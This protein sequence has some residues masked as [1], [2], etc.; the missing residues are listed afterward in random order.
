[1]PFAIRIATV[2]STIVTFASVAS[3]NPSITTVGP[4][5]SGS[6]SVRAVSRPR[7]VMPLRSVRFS[8]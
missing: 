3:L 8:L 4:A 7:T 2:E 6:S 1:M 5:E